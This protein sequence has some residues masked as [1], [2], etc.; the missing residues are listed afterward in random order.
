MR[1]GV[2]VK[3]RR[4]LRSGSLRSRL[5]FVLFGLVFFAL[6]S[7]TILLP[8]KHIGEPNIMKEREYDL[9]A[10]VKLGVDKHADAIRVKVL[11]VF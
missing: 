7:E 11:P 1:R 4:Y 9:S 10:A 8:G 5:V 2:S 3:L 6:A